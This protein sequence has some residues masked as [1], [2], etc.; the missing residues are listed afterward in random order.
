MAVVWKK[1]AYDADKVNKAT[2]TTKG[3]LYVATGASTIV[4]VGVGTD[5]H[6][7][8]ADSGETPGIKWAA[9]G[10]GGASLTVAETEVFNDTSPTSWTDL[11]LSATIGAQASLVLLKVFSTGV[12]L[13]AF[14]KNGD[15]DNFYANTSTPAGCAMVDIPP[16]EKHM[17]I[18]VATDA[19]GVIEWIAENAQTTTLDI[20]A[21]IK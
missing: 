12:G 9:A 2:L 15:T 20:I 3:D 11:N 7:L 19:A 1:I 18:I 21:Y 13:Y 10:G 16:V 14:R 6:V 17:V 5:T 4:R 8:T